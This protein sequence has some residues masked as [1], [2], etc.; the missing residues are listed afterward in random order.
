MLADDLN[1]ASISRHK[2]KPGRMIIETSPGNYQVWIHSSRPLTLGE[3]YYWL[4]KLGS[5]PGATPKCRFGRCPG[6]RNRKLKY[7]KL[8]YPLA[9][10]IWI[11]S[12]YTANI[13][14]QDLIFNMK[15]LNSLQPLEEGCR[16]TKNIYREFY[17]RGNESS[18]DF[19]YALALA[20]R[21]YDEHAI[22]N[23]ILSERSDWKNH[24]GEKRKSY[25]L[26][27]TVKRALQI[28]KSS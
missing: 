19:A 14:K 25:Y 22:K 7:V 5:D 26:N 13:P 17:Q 11:D 3:K 20:R 4:D 24:K 1:L 15:N 6:F 2:I 23:R 21:G 12:K 28:V 27:R 8:G 16:N 9:K 10:L 18:T